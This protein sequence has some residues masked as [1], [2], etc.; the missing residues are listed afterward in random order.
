MSNAGKAMKPAAGS[1]AQQIQMLQKEIAALKKKN[2]A[3]LEG[4]G[5]KACTVL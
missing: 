1:E 2:Q 4:A 5:S 3:L